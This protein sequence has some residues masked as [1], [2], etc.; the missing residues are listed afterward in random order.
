MHQEIL[1]E[2]LGMD[3]DDRTDAL[4]HAK[5]VHDGFMDEALGIPAGPERV[6]FL[7]SV[8]SERQRE[9]IMHKLWEGMLAKN[10]G[11]AP[12]RRE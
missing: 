6:L 10:G 2:L 12:V 8:G 3:E 4:A 11:E 5:E 1:G 7:Q 9:L